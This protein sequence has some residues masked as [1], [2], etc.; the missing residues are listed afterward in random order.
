MSTT[1]VF[2]HGINQHLEV[3][4]QEQLW[5]DSVI[6]SGIDLQRTPST[7]AYYSDWFFAGPRAQELLAETE[8]PSRGPIDPERRQEVDR[9]AD[10]LIATWSPEELREMQEVARAFGGEPTQE[11]MADFDLTTLLPPPL[12]RLFIRNVVFQLYDYFDNTAITHPADPTRTGRA[13]TIIRQ[14]FRKA[15]ADARKL[16]GESGQVIVLAHS[17]GSVVAWDCLQHDASCGPV[18][19]LVTFGS[20][21]G[22][23]FVQRELRKVSGNRYKREFPTKLNGDWHNIVANFDKVATLDTSFEDI[24]TNP[25][26]HRIIGVRTSNPEFRWSVRPSVRLISAHSGTGYLKSAAMAAALQSFG[27]KRR[28]QPTVEVAMHPSARAEELA[29]KR[30]R[31]H[32]QDRQRKKARLAVQESVLGVE[33]DERVV[34]RLSQIGIDY[35][36]ATRMVAE[37]HANPAGRIMLERVLGTPDFIQSSYALKMAALLSSVGQVL[38]GKAANGAPL[39]FGTGFMISPRL[40]M[41]NSH[42][43]GDE[44]A[45]A[46]STV[47]FDYA[48]DIDDIEQ[49]GVEVGLRP[50]IFFVASPVDDL[51]YAIV[52]VDEPEGGLGRPWSPLIA[53]SGKVLLGQSVNI[54]QHPRGRRQELITRNST[55]TFIDDQPDYAHYSGDTEPGSSGSPCYNDRWQLAFLHHASVPEMDDQGFYRKKNGQRWNVGDDPD[56][57]N[58][59]ANEGIRISRIVQDV[60]SKGLPEPR[61]NLFAECFEDPELGR[62]LHLGLRPDAA[63]GPVTERAAAQ[64]QQVLKHPD[65]R[66]SYL[67]EVSFGPYGGLSA[68]PSPASESPSSGGGAPGSA[69]GHSLRPFPA[70]TRLDALLE[71]SIAELVEEA[72]GEEPYY[73]AARDATDIEKYYAGIEHETGEV[74]MFREY[75]RLISGTQSRVFGYDSARLKVLYPYVDLHSDGTL[76]SIYSGEVMRPAEVILEEALILADRLPQPA[77]S[78]LNLG[79]DGLLAMSDAME[80]DPVLQESSDVPFNCE[81]VVPQSW[82][83]KRKPMVSDLHHLFTCERGCNSYRGNR[84]YGDLEGYDPVPQEIDPIE[85]E[86]R[87]RCGLVELD[88]GGALVFEPEQNK[89]VVAR[90]TLY[91]LLRYENEVGDEP[92]EMPLETVSTL[93]AW[94]EATPVNDYE[95]HRNRAIFLTQGNRNPLI[96]FPDL[97]GKLAFRESFEA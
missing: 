56:D 94:H 74:R 19:G 6:S 27:L 68:G 89:G 2:V 30:F 41:T 79:I 58:W 91:F 59:V 67:F 44:T 92:G 28:R 62:Y 73:D 65:G 3:R 10:E 36:T 8:F 24:F 80:T 72:G 13:R 75:H 47:R 87:E 25:T 78:I 7:F 9:I 85:A 29:A 32:A 1:I 40:L 90:A 53:G 12:I 35:G 66:V 33:V 83:D 77:E 93:L 15:V 76:R 82:Y 37:A 11:G 52:A 17:M 84:P 34:N 64:G 97:A 31:A 61:A 14:L 69:A 4:R 71:R 38:I 96:D 88:S 57:I 48:K 86:L 70:P 22:L 5:R 60:E 18:D 45:A 39:G 95:R 51:D 26:S 20:P 49:P 46:A 63:D 50:D 54:I 42:V 23:D 16:A 43:L 21:L 55:L 81:H